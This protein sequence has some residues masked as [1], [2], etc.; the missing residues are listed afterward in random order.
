MSFD[1]VFRRGGREVDDQEGV[2]PGAG[3][4]ELVQG[5]SDEG[6]VGER[7][8]ARQPNGVV[9]REF[10]DGLVFAD[11]RDTEIG[12]VRSEVLDDLMPAV[13]GT[14]ISTV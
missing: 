1:E 4:T 13:D 2:E 11:V 8:G 6:A 10:P 12:D 7:D 3:V 5:V 14:V 9:G